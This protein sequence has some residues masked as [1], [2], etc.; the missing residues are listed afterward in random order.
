[1]R[2][3]ILSFTF[4]LAVNVLHAQLTWVPCT[5]PV[6]TLTLLTVGPYGELVTFEAT[7]PIHPK[8]S[9]DGG[10]TW[11][12]RAG[13]G[14][15][16]GIALFDARLHVTNA[17]T[18]L[19]WGSG[20]GG[21]SYALWRSTDGG[22]TF[23]AL[24]AA[25]GI[26]GARYFMGFSS[27]P[28]GDVYLY[29]EGILR[30]TDDGQSWTSIVG[31]STA[32]TSMAVTTTHIWAVQLSAVYRGNLDGTGF[33]AISTGAVQ[34]TNGL[35][36]ARGMNDRII[37]VG[38]SDRVIT[39]ADGGSTWQAVNTGITTTLNNELAHIAASLSSDTWVTAKQI[40]VFSTDNG[41]AP[42][43][44][45]GNGLGLAGNEPVQ[46]VFCDSTGTFYLYG[47][48]HLY[49]SN[50]STGL[51]QGAQMRESSA[52]PNPTE[53]AVR[54]PDT[55]KGLSCQVCDAAG[56]EVLRVQVGYDGTVDLGALEAGRYHVRT[57]D[58]RTCPVQVVH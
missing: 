58:G 22:D 35:G 24:G 54:L 52:Y 10:Q 18:L 55:Y 16:N 21:S 11:Q 34:V 56:R 39:T 57:A 37:A 27:G 13:A 40:T 4:L 31:A 38:G 42:W 36:V 28:G 15:P 20:N 29:G 12:T 47:Y 1:M 9:T 2:H 50:T 19:L 8:V 46:G 49:R 48:F 41:G 44:N 53:G 43:A 14:G 51:A 33:T 25:N 23:T 26:P 7:S 6:N 3:I 30:S 17:G 5:M 32:L 45:A